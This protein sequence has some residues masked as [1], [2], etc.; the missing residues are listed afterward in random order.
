MNPYNAQTKEYKKA[1]FQYY[2]GNISVAPMTIGLRIKGGASRNFIKKSW[3]ISFNEFV[4]KQKLFQQK[5]LLLKAGSMEGTYVRERISRDLIYSM[6]AATERMVYSN[7]YIN[8]EYRGLFIQMDAIDDVFLNSRFGNSDG[9]LW[10]V[11]AAFLPT[12]IWQGP[13]C[14]NYS[15]PTEYQPNTDFA[16]NNCQVLVHLID[17]LNNAPNATFETD[18]QQIF[19]VPYFLRTLVVEVLTGNWD[20]GTYDGN[21]YYLYYDVS[22]TPALFKYIR[23]GIFIFIC[24]FLFI[25]FKY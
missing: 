25:I 7:L 5:K 6:G 4:S 3:K 18:V 15:I 8:G 19:D 1:T 21:N 9:G 22:T 11:G 16:T 13:D 2:N 20:G 12:L 23:Q 17:V 10:K 24:Y 14:A